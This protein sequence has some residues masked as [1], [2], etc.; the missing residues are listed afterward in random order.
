MQN[1]L[2]L[3]SQNILPIFISITAGYIF[4]KFSDIDTQPI[5]KVI[6]YV[7]VPCLIFNSLAKS[8]LSPDNISKMLSF[9]L[10]SIIGMGLIAWF[11]CWVLKV[12]R[13]AM[14]SIMLTVMFT[15]GANY[16][17]SLIRFAYGDIAAPYAVIYFTI[18]AILLFILGVMILTA[19]K[20]SLKDAF[21]SLTRLPV[22]YAML[23][24]IPFMIFQLSMPLPIDRAITLLSEA[25]IPASLV[26]LGMQLERSTF[27]VESIK[28]VGIATV[29]KLVIAPFFGLLIAA[30]LKLEGPVHKA[31][32]LEA[33]MP[34]A[35][36]TIL[37][38]D[39]FNLDPQFVTAIIMVTT[40]LSPISIT[41]LLSYLG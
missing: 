37:L 29:L 14:L 5:S 28:D 36:N 35:V 8:T 33:S 31:A 30:L 32:V 17:L 9:I 15:N 40:L 7:F 20:G 39:E 23:F 27:T 19:G 25:A 12:E 24:S 1:L 41:L 6:L 11:S 4:S 2:L 16:G 26:L 10:I 34:S 21:R 18:S 13:E 3:F 38:A 22:V